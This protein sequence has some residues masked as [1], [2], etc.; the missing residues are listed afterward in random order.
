MC[1][2]YFLTQN[3]KKKGTQGSE[4]I[5][6]MFFTV[7]SRAFLGETECMVVRNAVTVGVVWNYC[8][9]Y[10]YALAVL[11]TTVFAPSVQILTQ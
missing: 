11:P 7:S 6:L 1:T 9:N 8:L 4:L 5:K 10:C 2:S 3:N